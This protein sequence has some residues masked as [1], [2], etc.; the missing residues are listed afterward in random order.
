MLSFTNLRKTE[1][2]W[3]FENEAALENFVWNNL[4]HLL[5]LTPL[6]QQYSVKGERYDI[7]AV[8]ENQRLVVLELKNL[9]D[10]YIVQQLTRYCDNLQEEKPVDLEV[11]YALPIRLLAIAPKFHRHNFIDKKHH[12][13]NFEFLLFEILQ[14][15][16]KLYFKL[17]NL[18]SGQE[19]KVILPYSGEYLIDPCE[20]SLLVPPLP[21]ILLKFL[22][23]HS[24]D[25]QNILNIREKN[26][27]I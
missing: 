9:E 27:Q 7:L 1:Q 23:K 12:K 21:K 18:D 2:G 6:K 14:E 24:S 15:G 8:D 11:D 4:E 25:K 13:L 19:A 16:K 17:K 26:S 10:R 5:K 22:E 3:E 20:N